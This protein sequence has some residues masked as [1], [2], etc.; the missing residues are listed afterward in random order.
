ML[1]ISLM[2]HISQYYVPNTH[3]TV[4]LGWCVPQGDDTIIDLAFSLNTIKTIF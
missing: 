3:D 4:Q 2:Y 1:I